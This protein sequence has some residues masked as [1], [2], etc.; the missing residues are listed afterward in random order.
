MVSTLLNNFFFRFE[1]KRIKVRTALPG[2]PVQF[3]KDGG[4]TWRDVTENTEI[5][6]KILLVTR[7]VACAI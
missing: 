6:T 4:R 7:L 1:G 2:L 3:S 5:D